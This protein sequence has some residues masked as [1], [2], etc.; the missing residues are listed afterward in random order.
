[1][2]RDSRKISAIYTGSLLAISIL[3]FI[4]FIA[5]LL[6]RYEDLIS[7]IVRELKKPELDSLLRNKV[8]T[9]VKFRFLQKISLIALFVLPLIVFVFFKIKNLLLKKIRSLLEIFRGSLSSWIRV[10]ASQTKP[11]KIAFFTALF[12]IFLRSLYYILT[13]DLQYD[14][15]WSY[16]YFTASPFYF[17]FFNWLPLPGKIQIRLPVLLGG[18]AACSFLYYYLLKYFKLAFPALAAMILF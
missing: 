4:F 10:F 17:T 11:E 2:K 8:L 9:P 12:L 15:M 13:R 3:L 5:V 6:L 1:M 7:W 18:L 14:E 16:N